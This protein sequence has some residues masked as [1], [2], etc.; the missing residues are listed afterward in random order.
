MSMLVLLTLPFHDFC[1][2][3]YV[4]VNIVYKLQFFTFIFAVLLPVMTTLLVMFINTTFSIFQD[5]VV[6]HIGFYKSSQFQLL[7]RFGGSICVIM[8]NVV[9][10]GQTVAEIWPLLDF[11]RWRPS[12]SVICKSWKVPH[13]LGEP[14]CV[15]VPNFVTIA[16]PLPRYRD[17]RIFQNGGLRHVGFFK[18]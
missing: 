7:V 14:M 5:G 9:P 16:Q 10:I 1:G 15:T 3:R 11:S 18:R 13:L 6:R 12:A 2:F 17:F 8:P 4:A